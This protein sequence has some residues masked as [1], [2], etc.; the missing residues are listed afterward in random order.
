MDLA[1]IEAELAEIDKR[2]TF[3]SERIKNLLSEEQNLHKS[4]S[5]VSSVANELKGVDREV[6]TLH[7]KLEET[8][9]LSEKIS[10][11]VGI[12]VF[13]LLKDFAFI[14]SS[15]TVPKNTK[16]PLCSQNALFVLKTKGCKNQKKSNGPGK[17]KWGALLSFL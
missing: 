17:T 5:S 10:K 6:T 12:L 3:L 8:S 4:F 14:V 16:N 7:S 15:H 9:A 2:E 13:S 1:D 11:R